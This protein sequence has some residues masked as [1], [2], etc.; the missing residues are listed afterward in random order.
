VF[1]TWLFQQTLWNSIPLHVHSFSQQSNGVFLPRIVIRTSPYVSP[2]SGA[3]KVRTELHY[4]SGRAWVYCH[5]D[6]RVNVVRKYTNCP[7]K[8]EQD[9]LELEDWGSRPLRNV[10]NYQATRRKIPEY[11]TLQEAVWHIGTHLP[12]CTMSYSKRP[13][14]K[15]RK[16]VKYI[17]D[18]HKTREVYI[19]Q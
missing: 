8:V 5:Q 9:L 18:L 19:F 14:W 10:V 1:S 11:D 13:F 17:N 3:A 15:Q 7:G 4:H 12:R 6:R 2:G 16:P